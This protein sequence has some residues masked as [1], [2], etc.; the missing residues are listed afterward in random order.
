MKNAPKA[1]NINI[2]VQ[3]LKYEMLICDLSNNRVFCLNI[4]AGEVWKL[5]DGTN[6][7]PNI[8]RI[9]SKKLRGNVS[10]EM[11]LFSLDE[12]A[13]E[14]L[15][16]Q[17][18]SVNKV[19]HGVSRREVIR[20]LGFA[21]MVALPIITSVTMPYATQAASV[22]SALD[23]PCIVNSDCQSGLQCAPGNVCKRVTGSFCSSAAECANGFCTDSICCQT[24]C[25]GV[26][27]KCNISGRVGFCDPVPSGFDPDNECSGGLGVCN[28]SRAC[29]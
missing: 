19:F 7:I 20:R 8:A 21:S 15:L 28:G 5:C 3:E 16:E 10:E 25:S 2:V 1:R 18:V 22:L 24:S 9:L 6:D 14:N 4:T 11:V 23:G 17:K 13:K 12:L 26:C 27:E 29:M